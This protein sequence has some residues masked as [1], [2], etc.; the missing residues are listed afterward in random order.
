MRNSEKGSVWQIVLIILGLAFLYFIFIWP[1]DKIG[2]TPSLF[3]VIPNSWD[4]QT[5]YFE[6]ENV[7]LAPYDDGDPATNSIYTGHIQLDAGTAF[8]TTDPNDEY[9]IVRNNSNLPVN[10]TGFRLQNAKDVLA[11]PVGKKD[12]RYRSEAVSIPRAAAYISRNN[13]LPQTD[14]VLRGGDEAVITSGFGPRLLNR[15]VT[16]FRENICTGYLEEEWDAGFNVSTNYNSCGF[17]K[18]D[19]AIAGF[20]EKCRDVIDGLQSCRIPEFGYDENYDGDDDCRTCVNGIE[21]SNACFAFI[22]YHY[23]YEGC[24]RD[25]A[26]SIGFG[27]ETIRIFL[28]R[29]SELWN[30]EYETVFLYDREGKLID[31]DNY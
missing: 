13:S 28:E 31:Y 8:S 30:H 9:V 21:V 12:V 5:S 24:I 15:N 14:V 27:L 10:I 19:I 26:Y 17:D 20:D 18:D 1:I 6:D 29:R 22:K 2:P 4:K 11:Y 23:N 25:N 3:S 16:N 7:S